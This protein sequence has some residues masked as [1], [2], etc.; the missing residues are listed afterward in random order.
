MWPY[1]LRR[2]EVHGGI[3]LRKSIS[4]DVLGSWS[5]Y[6]SE[7]ESCKAHLVCHALLVFADILQVFMV[8]SNEKKVFS[9]LVVSIHQELFLLQDIPDPPCHSSI[10]QA[11]AFWRKNA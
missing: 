6:E 3:N 2:Y 5:V 11:S 10:Q 7:F 1:V 9:A 8:C 4:S